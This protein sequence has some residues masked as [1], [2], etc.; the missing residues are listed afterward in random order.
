VNQ[1]ESGRVSVVPTPVRGPDLPGA[2]RS[3]KGQ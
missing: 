2:A 3:G 1:A